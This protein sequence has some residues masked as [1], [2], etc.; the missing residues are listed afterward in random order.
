MKHIMFVMLTTL[1]HVTP[2]FCSPFKKL[3]AGATQGNP[4]KV[5]D[6]LEQGAT[7]DRI[8]QRT[9]R[10]A[11]WHLSKRY[12]NTSNYNQTLDMLVRQK[13]TFTKS[14]LKR[15]LI[16]GQ[17]ALAE[18]VIDKYK[19]T[20]TTP[21]CKN[22]Y[23]DNTQHTKN[24]SL[25]VLGLRNNILQ[26]EDI[27]RPLVRQFCQHKKIRYA[28]VIHQILEAAQPT[29]KQS[30]QLS[31]KEKNPVETPRC[32]I[33]LENLKPPV[34]T[35]SCYDVF[36]NRC[37]Q[38]WLRSS[39]DENGERIRKTCPVCRRKPGAINHGIDISKLV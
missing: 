3:I 10:S 6:A 34:A 29:K 15:T 28:K 17:Y 33:C 27:T 25:L 14:E 37:I 30:A 2:T 12:Q 5:K 16:T 36:H 11:F 31:D 4:Q 23:I 8:D 7:I 35:L 32:L 22:F 26:K 19:R 13:P 38:Q 20:S 1:T 24:I 9:G 21:I 39:R 18:A